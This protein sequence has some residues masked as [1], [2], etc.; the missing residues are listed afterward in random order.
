MSDWGTMALQSGFRKSEWAQDSTSLR[1]DKDIQRNVD[2]SSKAFVAS[3]FTFKG[4]QG[5][6]LRSTTKKSLATAQSVDACWRF[7]KNGDNGQKITY[8]K[9]TNNEDLCYVSATKNVLGRA[10]RL[11]IPTNKPLAQYAVYATTKRGKTVKVKSVQYI[12][13]KEIEKVLREAAAEVYDIKCKHKL[14]KF[15][16]HSFRVGACVQLHVANKDP[17]FIK[18]R[19][20]W[21][22]K[23]FKMYLRNIPALAKQHLQAL[24]ASVF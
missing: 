7:Q 15:S 13:D 1:K 21:R 18:F 17:E 2:G 23:A 20:R 6:H 8:V 11:K 3:D 19:L 5:K 16:S 4:T 12:T 10:T 22:S 9:D 24:T 14:A